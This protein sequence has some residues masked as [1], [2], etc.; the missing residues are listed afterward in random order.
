MVGY[1]RY[2]QNLE[3]IEVDIIRSGIDPEQ[4]IDLMCEVKWSDGASSLAKGKRSLQV[5]GK[6]FAPRMAGGARLVCTTK[7]TYG[8]PG[9]D[10]GVEFMPA[11]QYCLA[12]GVETLGARLR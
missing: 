7:S 6:R 10:G 12:Q 11:A 3:D 4:L 1:C 2:R 5:V 9:D 8:G